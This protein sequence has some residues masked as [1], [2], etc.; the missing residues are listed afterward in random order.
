MS[1]PRAA[2]NRDASA[3]YSLAS[4]LTSL[5]SDA[6]AQ[7]CEESTTTVNSSTGS[8]P[9]NNHSS[10]RGAGKE[11]NQTK[12][13][14]R[15]TPPRDLRRAAPVRESATSRAR[16]ELRRSRAAGTSAPPSPRASGRPTTSAPPRSTRPPPPPS[17]RRRRS[18]R[19]RA[20]R[21]LRGGRAGTGER[22]GAGGAVES[23]TLAEVTSRELR[24]GEVAWAERAA[25]W[26]AEATA[27]AEAASPHRRPSKPSTPEWVAATERRREA[28]A[29]AGALRRN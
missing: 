22:G 26:E 15:K 17:A 8:S 6:A 28:G 2:N 10:P 5:L 27:A 20:A 11:G 25:A 29:K 21:R 9:R 7:R 13:R 14:Q 23:L 19:G 3:S 4:T 18:G 24:S 1:F 12:W 16:A